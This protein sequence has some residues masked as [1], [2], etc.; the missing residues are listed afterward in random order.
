MYVIPGGTVP[1]LENWGHVTD[2]G[3]ELID[4]EGLIFGKFVFGGPD[5]P[6]SCAYFATTKGSF[7]M[8]YPFNEH[9][10]VVEGAITLTDERSGVTKDYAPGDAWFI[11]KGTPVLWVIHSERATK[12]YCATA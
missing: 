10:V 4:G 11:E 9:A 5:A 7:R 1:L 3:A 6:L 8:V 2:L 12:N